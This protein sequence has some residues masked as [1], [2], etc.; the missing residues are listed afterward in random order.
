MDGPEFAPLVEHKDDNRFAQSGA[1][2]GT[3]LEIR[4][5]NRYPVRTGAALQVQQTYEEYV[6][7][8]LATQK[9]VDIN[10]TSAELTMSIDDFSDRILK[11]AMSKL[12]SQIDYEGCSLYKDVYNFVG[13]PGTTPAS[14]LAVLQ[15][16][17]KLDEYAA[18]RDGQRS[19]VVNPAAN[20]ALINGMSTLFH[21]GTSIESQFS[22]GLMGNDVLGMNFYMDQNVNS[23]STGTRI[24]TV[25]I[26]D[27]GAAIA[28]GDST[29][30]MDGFTNATDTV[31]VGEVFTIAGVYGVN[32]ETGQ[33]TGALQ[34]FVVTASN[35]AAGNAIAA[36]AFSPTLRTTGARKTVTALPANNAA[37]LWLGVAAATNT[38][39]QDFPMNLA[40]HKDAFCLATAD[41]ELPKGVDFAHREVFDG[42]SLRVV[43]SYDINND[44]FPCRIDIYYGWK[45]IRAEMA[46][47]I[48]G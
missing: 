22:K 47:R 19:V 4:L 41:L 24:G 27:P 29:V 9:G 38:S 20:A 12:A 45:T 14:A 7:L 43:R 30:P 44:A 11:P 34:Q 1:K 21:K 6:T 2:I 32:P 33:S 46:C 35:T 15:S 23:L 18:P 17:Q 40:F 28:D 16:G 5:P 13:T 36:L 48:L 25:L 42:I 8:N 39:S 37:V 3:A 31:L 10:F 26:N